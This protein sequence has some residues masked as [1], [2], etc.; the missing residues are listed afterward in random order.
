MKFLKTLVL[1]CLSIS[2]VSAKKGPDIHQ[3]FD[4]IYFATAVTISAKDIHK[5]IRIADS[6]YRNST[7]EIHQLKALMLSSS[8]FQQKG[9]IKKSVQYAVKADS[10]A[11][12]YKIY[13]W[14]ARIAGF[15][16][17]QYRIMGLYDEGEEY[18]EKGKEVSN[19]IENE[20]MKKLYLGMIY[21]ETAY[22]EIEFEQYKKAYKAAKRADGYFKQLV[23]SEQDRTYFLATNEQLLGRICIGLKKWDDAFVHYN[24][25]SEKLTQVTQENAVLSGFIYSGLGR[26]YLEKKELV[27]AFENLQK[28]EKIVEQSGYLE[29]KIEVYKTLADYYHISK[30]YVK[31]SKYNNKYIEALELSEKKKKESITDFVNTTKS[32]G[33]ELTYNRN[34]LFIIS[35]ALCV[36]IVLTFVWHRRSRKRER[37]RFKEVMNKMR[38]AHYE[39][40]QERSVVAVAEKKDAPNRKIMSDAIEAKILKDLKEFERGIKYTDNQIS[41][42][43]LAGM[44]KTNTK[45]LSHVLNTYLN[46]DFNTYINE[47]RIKYIIEKIEQDEKFKNYKLSVLAEECGFSSHSKFSAVFK[48]VTG[49]SPSTFLQYLEESK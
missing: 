43:I 2:S 31:S 46:K 35:L 22:Y 1:I 36:I 19:K 17:T 42:P 25:A 34:L 23:Y 30:D 13:D 6:L 8:L 5:A 47:L 27:S 39:K 4:S 28:A 33:K 32:E 45:Y 16:S 40:E 15:L 44:L 37:E 12:K 10:I 21:Q 11:V 26:I 41:L 14:E 9:D 38:Q 18:L 48:S 20:Q 24:K 3:K 49:F 7:L 29:L